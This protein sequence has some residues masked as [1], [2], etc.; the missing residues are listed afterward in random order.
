MTDRQTLLDWCDATLETARFKDYAPNGLQ[1]E[2]RTG[3]RRIL[4]AVTA[5]RAAIDHAV[6]TGAD[7][8]L[9]H[10]G[11]FWK[12]EPATITGWKKQRI[13]ALLAHDINL[14]GYHLPLD[15]HP[16]LGNNAQLAKRC[17]WLPEYCFGDQD[18]LAAGRNGKRGQTLTGLADDIAA[19]LGRRPTVAGDPE[20][21]LD[22]LVWCSGGAQGYFQAAIDHGAD[23]Y[24]TGEI[25]EAQYH[26]ANETGTVFIS[27]GHHATERYGIQALGN[28]I[29]DTFGI[30]V[31]FFDEANPA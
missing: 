8:L 14:A 21:V 26:L 1:V 17:G 19:A 28:A 27:A 24:I 7:M 22:K 2:G 5:S 15:A 18:L 20:R 31:S 29:A 4:T 23:A 11:M 25:S 16:E 12:S 6:V 13:A 3:I 30:E 9:V 10:H